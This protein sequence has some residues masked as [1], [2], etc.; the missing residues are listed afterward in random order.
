[1]NEVFQLCG[2]EGSAYMQAQRETAEALP[3][4]HT[5]GWVKEKGVYRPEAS[6]EGKALVDRFQ[7]LSWYDRTHWTETP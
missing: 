6:E 2:W 3:V 5:T 1:M 4:L 7:N